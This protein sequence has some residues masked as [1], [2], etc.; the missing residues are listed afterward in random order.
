MLIR[1][2]ELS[3]FQ[4]LAAINKARGQ[5]DG[6]IFA[7]GAE[8]VHFAF[9]RYNQVNP[10]IH[11]AF[12]CFSKAFRSWIH[13][14]NAFFSI[15]SHRHV[16]VI[17]LVFGAL[18]SFIQSCWKEAF[19]YT[20]AFTPTLLRQTIATWR[21]HFKNVSLTESAGLLYHSEAVEL[22]HYDM[23]DRTRRNARTALK[24]S[25]AHLWRSIS[26]F[27]IDLSYLYH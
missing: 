25:A 21:G 14:G 4:Q 11:L 19:G 27:T 24:V 23:V 15:F 9:K 17:A 1:S 3:L 26:C 10:H 8:Y 6:S 13:S 7:M 16:H 20:K 18:F 12:I 5:T 2:E 22:S